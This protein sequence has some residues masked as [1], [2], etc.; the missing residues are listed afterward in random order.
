MLL[1][2]GKSE[3]KAVSHLVS[4]GI[5]RWPSSCHGLAWRKAGRGF[6]GCLMFCGIEN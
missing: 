6:L 3:I 4:D 5:R 2:V 1:K